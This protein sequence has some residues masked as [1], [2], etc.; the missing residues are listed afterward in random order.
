MT[1]P[2]KPQHA[3][4]RNTVSGAPGYEIGRHLAGYAY[5]ANGNVDNPTPRYRWNLYLDGRLVDSDERRTP[6]VL[7]AQKD[8]YR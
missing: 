2:L 7:E 8:S 6:L 5:P 1:T 4:K 3:N